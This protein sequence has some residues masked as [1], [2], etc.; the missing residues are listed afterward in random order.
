VSGEAYD[1]IIIGSGQHGLILGSYLTRAGLKVLLLE[2]RHLFGG[3]LMTEE[4]TLPGFL[5]NLHSINHFSITGTP[6]FRDL[7]LSTRVDYITP[8]YEFA[9]PHQD[10]TAL[11][12]S[13]DLD[14]TLASISR[15]SKRDAET[16]RQWNG[17]AEEMTRR[18]FM[19]ERYAEPLGEQ[20]RAEL[21]GRSK[22]GR[23]FLDLTRQQ[24]GDVIESL[25]EDERVRV[26]FLFKLS[27]F[28]TVLHE[29]LGASSPLGSLIRAF[30]L[31]T[32]YEVCKGGSWNLARG[33]METYIASGGRFVNSAHVERIVVEGGR[34]TG[35]ELE[36][37]RSFT[38]RQFVASTVDVHQTLESMV[39][40]AQLQP[41][42]AEKLD[43]FHYTDWTLF[44]VH[45]ALEQAPNYLAAQFDPN[46]N[47]A[48]KYNIG[49]ETVQSLM[50][51][52]D[53]V[54][55]GRVPRS[56]QFGAGAL[57]VLDPSQAPSG[58][59]TAYAWHVV[60]FAPDGDHEN[61]RKLKGPM[62][63]AILDKWRQYAPNMGGA[64]VLA[65]YTYTAYEYAQELINMRRGDIFMGALSADQ[66]MYNHFGY[67][68]PIGGLYLAGSATHPNGAITGGAGYI[69]AGLIARDLDIQP[70][71][72]PVDLGIELDGLDHPEG[73]PG[74]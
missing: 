8:K 25:F 27:L 68:T 48:L 46:I 2:R 4:R 54:G 37:G 18:I 60:P 57:S 29:A 61:L 30:D 17:A 16:F 43:R 66:V 38:A 36:D 55:S 24:P 14:E 69:S 62:T 56:V 35:V 33:L 52:H 31:A 58:R 51:A 45:L 11:V 12:F 71:W 39:G 59:H 3:G 5:H 21:L 23:D 32:G 70:W 42:M 44:G 20:A 73:S 63:E 64:N 67:R 47:R 26:L 40:R 15:F 41:A 13:R 22:L 9:Q 49:S 7:E 1:G 6:W 34:A 72:R 50:D 53:D 28:G 10:G 19:K 65:T 74:V